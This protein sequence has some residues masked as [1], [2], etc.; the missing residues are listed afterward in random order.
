VV[1]SVFA[2]VQA[3]I[4]TVISVVGWG[5]PLSDAVLLG[6]VNFE[7]FVTVAATCVASALLGM[8]LSAL[9]QSQDQIM[10]MLVVSI[11]SQLVFSG[12]MIWVTDRFL[13]DQLS[14]FTPAR[15]GFAASASTIDTH[16][17]IPGPTDPKDSHWDHTKAAWLFDMAM[18]AVLCF[19]YSTIVW[20]KIRLKRH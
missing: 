8:A 18:L 9:A 14:W 20:W 1:F 19:A 2:I 13:L 11:M 17:L 16:R 4:A 3:A 10:P 7:L 12:G 5:T 15:W 6:N